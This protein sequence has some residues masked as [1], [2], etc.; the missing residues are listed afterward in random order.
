MIILNQ[1]HIHVASEL[2][3]GVKLHLTQLF[4]R[5]VCNW[6]AEM[7]CNLGNYGRI[8]WSREHDGYY[9]RDKYKDLLDYC[10]SRCSVKD[11]GRIL[12]MR[13]VRPEDKGVYR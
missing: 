6:D 5:E 9:P 7:E 3:S 13:D 2:M 10:G 11:G 8:E 1:E 12:E 4:F